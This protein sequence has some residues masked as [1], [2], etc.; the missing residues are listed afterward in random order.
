M[1]RYFL[2]LGAAIL[3]SSCGDDDGPGGIQLATT[4]L[5]EQI[6]E[7]DAAI[8]DYLETHFYNY[9]EF[10][11]PPENFNFRVRIEPITGDNSDKIPLSQQVSSAVINVSSNE[12]TFPLPGEETDVP[13]TYYFLQIREG[14][15]PSPT[16]GDST[17]VKVEGQ[18]LDGFV[19]ESSADFGW[20][21]LYNTVRGFA[22]S[23]AQMKG[24][25]PEGIVVNP[26]GSSQ[27]TDSGIGLMIIPSGLGFFNRP[28]EGSQV[29]LFAPLVFTFEL[30][31]VTENTDTD[32]DGIPNME[33]DLDED[34]FLFDD[35]TDLESEIE[36]G[37]QVAFANFQDPDDDGDGVLTRDEIS[38][39]NGN[40]I[41]PYPD[42][43]N[44]GT[45]DYLDLNILREPGN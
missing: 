6:V 43:N 42:T 29:P 2:L 32:N 4:T 35:N 38:D 3:V 24:G 27:I 7:D 17:L 16:V 21:P 25:T 37:L 31:L 8:L 36:R 10:Q 5:A 41:F 9:E 18:L 13:H 30:G 15:G 19:F 40:I 1:K 22:N 11:N 14:Q 23:M 45:P 44:D 33:E 12:T 20:L 26:D 34:G 28:R 39:E